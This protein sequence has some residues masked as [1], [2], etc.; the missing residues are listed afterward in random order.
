MDS[1]G[2]HKRYTAHLVA[3]GCK[4]KPG[5]N[6]FYTYGPLVSLSTVWLVLS[7]AAADDY[8][9]HQHD[10]VAAFL[11]SEIQE[12]IYLRLPLGFGIVDGA[13][14]DT[15]LCRVA[16]TGKREPLCLCILKSLYG[17]R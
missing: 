7:F 5:I 16:Y 1:E 17:F 4:Q 2:G 3:H 9:I 10:V 13:I 11:E 6:F 8:E 14:Q 12:E 15:L